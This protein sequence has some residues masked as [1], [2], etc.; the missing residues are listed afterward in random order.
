ME[1]LTAGQFS[2]DFTEAAALEQIDE[3]QERFRNTDL[4]IC[5][6]VGAIDTRSEAQ[7]QLVL[8]IDA[9]QQRQGRILLTANRSPGSLTGFSSRFVNRCHG[10]LCVPIKPLSLNSRVKMVTHLASCQQILIPQEQ[11][12]RLSKAVKG[13][14]RD[15]LGAVNQLDAVARMMQRPIDAQLCTRYLEGDIEVPVPEIKV[16]TRI[17][18]QEFG[19]NV[20]EIRSAARDKKLVLARQCAMYLAREVAHKPLQEIARYFGGRNHST[21]IHSCRRFQER[22]SDD[23]A[24]GK[25][26]K[27]ILNRLGIPSEGVL[28]SC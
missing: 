21:V 22:L 20:G 6:D 24:L 7:N 17:V 27:T 3:F 10:G 2:A 15:L 23:A 14:V 4:F 9:V 26:L 1:H 8:A 25:E 11:I 16:I 19:V 5:E 12:Q 28:I 18:S 13:S